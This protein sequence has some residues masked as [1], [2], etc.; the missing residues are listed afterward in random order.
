VALVSNPP[1]VRLSP[2]LQSA[3]L[4]SFSCLTRT[5]YRVCEVHF[6]LCTILGRKQV[7]HGEK[8][9]EE[10]HCAPDRIVLV[11]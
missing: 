7:P 1:Q 8:K 2:I 4:S 5:T 6:L 9:Q 10:L 11:T 3:N